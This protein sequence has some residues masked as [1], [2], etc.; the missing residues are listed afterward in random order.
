MKQIPAD[1]FEWHIFENP[2]PVTASTVRPSMRMGPFATEQECRTVLDT[3]KAVPTFRDTTLEVRR[4]LRSR[5]K[6]LRIRLAVRVSPLARPDFCW[7][8]HTVD[9]SSRGAR[10]AN[11]GHCVRLGEFLDVRYGAREGIFRVVWIGPPNTPTEGNVGL[12]C[13][14]PETNIWDLDLSARTDDEPLMQEIVVAHN[15]QRRLFPRHKPVLRTLG[16]SGKCVQA[17]TVGGDYYDFL[18]LGS[19]RVGFV[20]AD[21]A[22]KGVAAAL[23][24]ANLQ[25]SLHNRAECPAGDLPAILA[26]VNGH[27]YEHTEPNC[28]ATVFFGCYDDHARSLAY[29]NCGH[30]PALLLRECGE[31]ERLEATAT[32]LGLFG[33]WDCSVRATHL[34][35]GDVLSIFTD[36][37]TEATSSNGDEFGESGVLSVLR[38]TRELETENIL[39][40]IEQAVEEFRSAEYPQDDLTMVV[41]RAR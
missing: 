41:A 38:Q 19:G 17:R 23:L 24:M 39:H 30:I 3:L 29:V 1:V 34:Q 25:G 11:S 28:Y 9:I 21:V 12:E 2:G 18:D 4:S 35:T 10:L 16:Y 26:A 7:D 37:V 15:V 31:V 14:S 5:E 27:L 13:L 8:G 33:N 32:V 6:R 20:L 40:K 22:G 36:G